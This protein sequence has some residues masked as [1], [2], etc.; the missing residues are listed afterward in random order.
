VTS[1]GLDAWLHDL[2]PDGKKLAFCRSRAGKWELREKS[3]ADGR[4]SPIV[5]DD[6]YGRELARW[7]PDGTSLAY[8]RLKPS[9]RETQ[10]VEWSSQSRSEEPLTA[11]SSK[12]DPMVFDWSPDGKWLLVSQANNDTG[13]YEI[14]QLSVAARPFAEIAAQKIIFDPAYLSIRAAF[15]LMDNG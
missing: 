8:T 15:P 3:L 6:S 12:Q 9:T 4:E 2:S 7:S 13:R 14:W 5:A 1:P 10:I 11:W